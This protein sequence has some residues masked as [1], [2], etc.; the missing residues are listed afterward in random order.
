MTE[1]EWYINNRTNASTKTVPHRISII[2]NIVCDYMHITMQ[3]LKSD[4]R[5][6][7]IPMCRFF[8]MFFFWQ[9]KVYLTKTQIGEH[10]KRDHATA[11]HGINRIEFLRKNDSMIR[12][13]YVDL[14]IL[15]NEK[16]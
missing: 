9:E 14:F 6:G 4:S 3:E 10:F 13:Y 11:I 7:M 8:C 15:I 16:S 1:M 12:K 5:K 2:E